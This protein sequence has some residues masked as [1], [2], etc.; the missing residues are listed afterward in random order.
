MRFFKNFTKKNLCKSIINWQMSNSIELRN[1]FSKLAFPFSIGNANFEKKN[2][3]SRELLSICQ[4]HF[5]SLVFSYYIR[6]S[7]SRWV[8]SW[9]IWCLQQSYRC[10][11]TRRKILD[12]LLKKKWSKSWSPKKGI[13]EF[14]FLFISFRGL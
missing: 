13:Y 14:H 3:S 7:V 1:F 8:I 5:S 11:G 10:L 6:K 2:R 12:T 4:L 9:L